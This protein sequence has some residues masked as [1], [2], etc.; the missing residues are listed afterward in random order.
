MRMKFLVVAGLSLWFASVL[1]V[2]ATFPDTAEF[3]R[4]QRCAARNVSTSSSYL[5]VHVQDIVKGTEF[6]TVVTARDLVDAIALELDVWDLAGQQ[7][8]DGHTL[9][10]TEAMLIRE[11]KSLRFLSAR[12]DFKVA[13]SSQDAVSLLNQR[14]TQEDLREIRGQLGKKNE[15][16][17]YEVFKSGGIFHRLYQH[18]NPIVRLSAKGTVAHI[19]LERGIHPSEDDLSANLAL[20]PTP[21]EMGESDEAAAGLGIVELSR[22][23]H[24]L[25]FLASEEPCCW[26][27]WAEKFW[28]E[29][30]CAARNYSSAPD[31]VV[32][33]VT[34]QRSGDE[35]SSVVETN[36][37][38][39]TIGIENEMLPV[40]THRE[41]IA[42]LISTHSDM[43]FEFGKDSAIA[44]IRPRYTANHLAI[45]RSI[46]KGKTVK[47]I[48]DDFS[49]DRKLEK[50]ASRSES[51]QERTAQQD[52][53]AYVLLELG[54][55][56]GRGDI[57]PTLHVN[58]TPCSR[59]RAD[60]RLMRSLR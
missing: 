41:S 2:T 51:D 57:V 58:P 35:F 50:I 24:D 15:R 45:A 39:E 54:Y 30:R 14:Y 1:P 34:D 27:S 42:R 16:E 48:E 21:C 33:H 9:N 31:Y 11:L 6:E 46:L 22:R 10:E 29:Q 17:I 36:T 56:P 43:R 52:A 55:Y 44:R 40:E 28:R 38:Y 4:Q 59:E 13:L 25:S 18:S 5:V 8:P 26:M 53:I 12:L 32:V 37:L 20:S 47:E 7:G 60:D 3:H 49:Q 19:L 23:F